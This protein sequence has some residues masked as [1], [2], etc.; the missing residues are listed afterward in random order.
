MR[1]F[2]R[3]LSSALPATTLLA[4]T[5]GAATGAMA[6]PLLSDMTDRTLSCAISPA[7]Y[8]DAKGETVTTFV[9]PDAGG[10][11]IDVTLPLT[12]PVLASS[13]Q[14]EFTLLIPPQK[15][16]AK[17]EQIAFI[18]TFEK[19][20]GGGKNAKPVPVISMHVDGDTVGD[21]CV[22]EKGRQK[23]LK[24]RFNSARENSCGNDPTPAC[25][26]LLAKTCG[27]EITQDCV[28]K[29]QPELAKARNRR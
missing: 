4:A 9:F 23:F 19:P 8:I 26:K 6:G 2:P 7:L 12:S 24:N 29:L 20:E 25:E 28:A 18:R 10:S 16:Q 13:S 5:L 22:A 21:A 14:D 11:W 1:L 15:G 27:L 17:G 3:L